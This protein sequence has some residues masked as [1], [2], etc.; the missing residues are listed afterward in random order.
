MKTRC[1][2]DHMNNTQGIG[3]VHIKIFP[4]KYSPLSKVFKGELPFPNRLLLWGISSPLNE[5]KFCPQ[6]STIRLILTNSTAAAAIDYMLIFASMGVFMDFCIQIGF[7]PLLCAVTEIKR[8][9]LP[10]L[11]ACRRRCIFTRYSITE[12]GKCL[13]FRQRLL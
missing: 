12:V 11:T 7:I 2:Q 5:Y 10:F 1:R 4:C 6:L 3:G 8:T 13:P 9:Q